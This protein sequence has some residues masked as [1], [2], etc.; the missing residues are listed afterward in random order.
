MCSQ[1][2]NRSACRS[3]IRRHN[4]LHII[5][6]GGQRILHVFQSFFRLPVFG[7]LIIYD[8]NI[9]LL[10]ERLQNVHCPR[11]EHMRVIIRISSA[12]VDDIAFRRPVDDGL[13]LK[14]PDPDIIK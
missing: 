6:H 7:E 3:V 8:S 10:F 11:L 4:A 13:G 5:L 14:F 12:N 9:A 1:G 2:L